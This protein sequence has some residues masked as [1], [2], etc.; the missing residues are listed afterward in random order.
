MR[1]TYGDYGSESSRWR[2]TGTLPVEANFR[3]AS[4][5]TQHRDLSRPGGLLELLAVK[6]A[7]AVLR[8]RWAQQGARRY[9]TEPGVAGEGGSSLDEV[10]SAEHCR[11]GRAR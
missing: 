3:F 5:G 7:R 6:A 1:T 11:M 9:P 8:G 2:R 10:G 4:A